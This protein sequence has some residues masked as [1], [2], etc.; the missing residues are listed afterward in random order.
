[1]IFRKQAKIKDNSSSSKPQ[2][3]YGYQGKEGYFTKILSKFSNHLLTK[4][5][6]EFL[7]LPEFSKHDFTTYL[8]I[9]SN[10]RTMKKALKHSRAQEPEE[11]T[12]NHLMLGSDIDKLESTNRIAY[13]YSHVKF[14]EFMRIIEVK[15]LMSILFKTTT[16]ADFISRHSA[17]SRNQS[18]ISR[19]WERYAAHVRKLWYKK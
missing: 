12:N 16:I 1:M 18:R 4:Y 17:L 15:A 13:S 9:F 3:P 8:G 10:Y 14:Y 6:Q 5:G 7:D 19:H 2:K 11:N